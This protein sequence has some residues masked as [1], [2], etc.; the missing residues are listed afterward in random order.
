[1]KT[2]LGGLL[3]LVLVA[4]ACQAQGEGE[5]DKEKKDVPPVVA[6]AKPV[7]RQVADVADF[8]GR[9]AA[10]DSVTIQPRVT[11]YIVKIA[12][13]EGAQVQK[14]QVLYEI[15]PRPYQAQLRAAEA[16]TVQADAAFQLASA[17][18]ARAMD[19]EK[20]NPAFISKSEVAQYQFQE[21]QA[22]A[23]LDLAKAD[24]ELAKLNLDWTV[25]RAPISGVADRTQLTVGNLVK[26]DVTKLTTVMS[27]DPIYVHFHMDE[28]TLIRFRRNNKAGKEVLLSM[29]LQG[30]E[31]FPQ[32]GAINFVDNQLDSKNG[33]ALVRGVF[34]NPKSK[35]GI[36]LLF[37]G[38]AASVRLPMG[39]PY[40]ALL[41]PDKAGFVQEGL[42]Y[43][44]VVD[45]K[46]K[47]D[48]RQVEVGPLQDDGLRVITKGLTKDDRVIVEALEEYRPGMTVLPKDAKAT[49]K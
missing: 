41:V 38:M 47:L 35:E 23:V 33:A 7:Q 3:V 17:N 45:A 1:M 19:L 28:A 44:Y 20:K 48:Q 49:P 8:F 31:G 18:R 11:G 25:I 26:Q 22:A 24:L 43:V 13:E 32:R 46:N 40:Q 5:G 27:L 42:K 16:K 12:Y 14:D 39:P 10:K 21:K 30:D 37:P 6:V 9:L 15:D 34:A 29:G 4:S 36:R 2:L